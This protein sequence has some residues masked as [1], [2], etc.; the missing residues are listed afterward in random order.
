MNAVETLRAAVEQNPHDTT[1]RLILADAID[2]RGEP[3]DDLMARWLRLDVACAEKRRRYGWCDNEN[4]SELYR[5]ER[6]GGGRVFLPSLYRVRCEL[7]YK[8]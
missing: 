4:T 7:S 1:A 2:E 8:D 3:G 6:R 5:V